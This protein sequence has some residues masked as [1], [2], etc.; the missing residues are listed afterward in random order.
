MIE[1]K[2]DD[3]QVL[4]ALSQLK[5]KMTTGR[6]A[7]MSEIGEYLTESTK[8]RFA[9]SRGPDGQAW[10]ANKE[11]TLTK[12][13]GQTKGNY[14]KVRGG[15]SAKGKRRIASKKPLIG[16][17]KA[18]SGGIYY[19]ASKDDVKVGSSLI[20]AAVQQFGAGKG[21]F[22]TTSKGGPIPWGSIPARPYLGFSDDDRSQILSILG[23]YL[24]V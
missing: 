13:L 16:P 2:F 21:A 5:S 23:R 7:V 3:S 20:Y 10:A 11:S 18:L 6:R 4:A 22:G 17:S 12:M 9:E 24:D 19:K 15:I 8:E 14:R 1:I